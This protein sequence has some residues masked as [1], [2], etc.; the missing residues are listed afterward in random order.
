MG[1]WSL[2]NSKWWKGWISVN[3][4]IPIGGE[5]KYRPNPFLPVVGTIQK[6]IVCPS[7]SD[8]VWVTNVTFDSSKSGIYKTIDGGNNWIRITE[9]NFQPAWTIGP[10]SI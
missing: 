10:L 3:T 1:R 5:D 9:D 6:I 7:N 4:G 8:I 2:Q